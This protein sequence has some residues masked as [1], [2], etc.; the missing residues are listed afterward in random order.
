MPVFFHFL[1]IFILKCCNQILKIIKPEKINPDLAKNGYSIKADIWSLGI[2]LVIKIILIRHVIS[3]WENENLSFSEKI[4]F[5]FF[6][7]LLVKI[8]WF[9]SLF[10]SFIYLNAYLSRLF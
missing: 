2:S 4:Y 8:K 3:H 7:T 1:I 9:L 6:F 10:I 5:L